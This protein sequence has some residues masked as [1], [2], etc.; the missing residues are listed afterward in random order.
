MTISPWRLF[1]LWLAIVT[2]VFLLIA[3]VTGIILAFEPVYEQSFGYKRSEA[4]QLTV[5]ALIENT[6]DVYPEISSISKDHNGYYL[7]TV[8][9]ESG[10]STFY[11][12]PFTGERLGELIKTPEI[13]DFA[14]TLHRSLYLKQTGRFLI[15]ITSLLLVFISIAGFVL[16]VRKQGGIRHY[17]KKV[18][19]E[20]F[21]QDYHTKLG[22]AFIWVI[23]FVSITGTILFLQRFDVI[24]DQVVN[25]NYDVEINAQPAQVDSNVFQSTQLNDFKKL[26]FPFSDFDDDYFELKLTNKE[27]LVHQ[28]NFTI[29]SQ[30]DYSNGTLLS[31]FAFKWHTGEGQTWWAIVL[32]ISSV[33]L[34]FFIYS[35][36]AIYARRISSRSKW[37]NNISKTEAEIIIA[38]GSETGSTAD[39]ASALHRAFKMAGMKAYI[40]SLNDF[41]YFPSMKYLI[42]MTSTYGKGDAPSN[43]SQFVRKFNLVKDQYDSF[44]FSVVGFGSKSYPDFCQYAVELD[45]LMEEQ[46][47]ASRLLP[48]HKIEDGSLDGLEKWTQELSTQLNIELRIEKYLSKPKTVSLEVLRNETSENSDDETF[49]LELSGRKQDLKSVQSGDLLAIS[50][51]EDDIIRYYSLSVDKGRNTI[52]LSIKKHKSGAVSNYL[53]HFQPGHSLDAS[54]KSNAAFHFPKK[55]AGVLLIAN[56]TG[57]APFLGML[58]SN[59]MKIPT[60]LFWGGQNESSLS[61]YKSH[62]TS[63]EKEGKLD[64]FKSAFSRVENDPK[65]VQQLVKENETFVAAILEKRG[66]IMIC[67]SLKMQEGV[68]EELNKI[69]EK[70]LGCSVE[71]YKDRNLILADCY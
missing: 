53:S 64:S 65:Y 10:E 29:V 70:H 60:T 23:L 68:E 20:N 66:T 19:T 18:V 47:N 39:K 5:A 30:V 55:S 48:L 58:A 17:F 25:H 62:L 59:F 31:N 22:K 56:G 46:A 57:I 8:F 43:A 34:L 2:A 13:F 7:I 24:A 51:P 26:V 14:R 3:S 41:E 44:Y 38:V 36:F 1:H 67:G 15:G 50:S 37:Q 71:Y 69:T 42:L 49:V 35:G 11:I 27:L 21:Y 63:L 45:L 9:D 33:G 4:N 32:G 40:V 12:D 6:S 28:K 61:L 54:F 16:V 52:L